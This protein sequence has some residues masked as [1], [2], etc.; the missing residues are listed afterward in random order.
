MQCNTHVDARL[1]EF[2]VYIYTEE[3]CVLTKT[4]RAVLTTLQTICG[5]RKWTEAIS[6]VVVPYCLRLHLCLAV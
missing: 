2:T 1:S 4:L 6:L 3:H 5:Y